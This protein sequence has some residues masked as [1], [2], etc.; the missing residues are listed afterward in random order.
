MSNSSVFTPAL[1]RTHSEYEQ[2]EM[3]GDADHRELLGFECEDDVRRQ[4]YIEQLYR[5]RRVTFKLIQLLQ[6][7]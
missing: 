2:R 1:L 6:T 3:K 4:L 7:F 5:K